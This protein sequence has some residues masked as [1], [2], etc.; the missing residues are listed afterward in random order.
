MFF[1]SKR[2]ILTILFSLL[3]C[4]LHPMM[5]TVV[6]TFYSLLALK[7]VNHSLQS[8]SIISYIFLLNPYLIGWIMPIHIL[9]KIGFIFIIFTHT[10]LKFNKKVFD[11]TLFRYLTYFSLSILVINIFHP[12]NSLKTISILKIV[13]FYF[14]TSYLVIA[15]S[16]LRD[17][18][19]IITWMMSIIYV[20]VFGSLFIYLFMYSYGLYL[21]TG[22][23][24]LYRGILLHPNAV[25]ILLIP[26][27]IILLPFILADIKKSRF[28]FVVLIS[29]IFLIFQSGARG[30]LIGFIISFIFS[31]ILI[32]FSKYRRKEFS[33]IF[34]QSSG[35]IALSIIFLLAFF[36][37]S[38]DFFLS[39]LIKTS[40]IDDGN[41]SDIFLASRG[42]F[43]TFS[44][45]NF[46][47]NPYWGIGYGIPSVLDFEMMTFDPIFG[48]P[49]SAPSEKA[50]F[51]TAILEE[52]GLIGTFI[53][54]IFYVKMSLYIFKNVSSFFYI[55]LFFSILGLS[56]FEFYFFSMGTL[57]SFN[58]IWIAFLCHPSV[59]HNSLRSAF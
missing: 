50:F 12:N 13:L 48:L 54:L 16:V 1:I 42:K 3:L 32:L 21:E 43:I 39:F 46:T 24:A 10:L 7:S 2:Y 9:I 29:I 40:N 41:L 4:A 18:I 5:K 47:E 11:I 49:I 35:L 55:L 28:T 30:S 38:K 31:L 19:K 57:G 27:F 6:L 25:G 56:I 26:A 45:L 37:I 44:Y 17:S 53:F 15:F 59:R 36:M 22:S 23:V 14:T 52:F 20:T 34:K 58:W 51:F 33:A 8:F